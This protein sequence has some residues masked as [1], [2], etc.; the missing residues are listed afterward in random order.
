MAKKPRHLKIKKHQPVQD[1][2]QLPLVKQIIFWVIASLIP[3]LCIAAV[4]IS[5]RISGYEKEKQSLFVEAPNSPDYLLANAKFIERYFPSFVPEIAPNAFLKEKKPNTFRVFVFGGS[6]AEG[7]PYNFYNSFSDQLE[8][9]LLLNT[10]GL[11]IEII[12]LGMTAVNSFVIRDLSPRILAYEPDA[13]IIYAGHNEYYGSFGA[14]TTQFGFTDSIRLKHTILWLKNLRVYQVLEQLLSW[15]SE[16]NG[17]TGV[18]NQ[19]DGIGEQRTMMAKVIQ[20]SNIPVGGDVYNLGIRQFEVNINDVLTTFK[21]QEIPIYLGTIASNLKDQK[22]LTDD[23][24]A[25]SVF[26]EAQMFYKSG[27]FTRAFQEFERAKELD[28]IRFRAPSKINELLR[29]FSESEGIELVETQEVLRQAS[30]SGLEDSTLFIDHLHPNDRGHKLMAALFFDAL[31]T[32]PTIERAFHPNPIQPP[33]S[34]STFEKAYAEVSIGR[35]LVGYPFQKGISL[36][37]E[38]DAFEHIY[39]SYLQ[40]SYIDSI[41]AVASKEQVFVP[42]ALSK[43]VVLARQRGD[44][45]AAVT[46]SYDLLKWQLQSIN[47][48]ETTI[49]FTLNSGENEGYLINILHQVIND[50]NEDPRYVDLISSLYLLNE[51]LDQAEFWLKETERLAPN[52]PRLLYNYSRFYLLNGDSLKARTYYQQFLETQNN[53]P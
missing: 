15:E 16:T 8:Q 41:A 6:S 32:H 51:Q 31:R 53:R 12:N 19:D 25:M 52:S 40:K 50:G 38:L 1:S 29:T 46:H 44:T 11:D 22:P 2:V 43:A 4:E 7:F 39:Q 48:I 3:F 37:E 5:L 13:V 47:L 28:G 18:P 17:M 21:K 14:A 42:E 34:I 30:N 45:M 10:Q 26:E 36:E 24:L 33:Q 20:D 49:E 9:Q 23:S 35:L 27:D